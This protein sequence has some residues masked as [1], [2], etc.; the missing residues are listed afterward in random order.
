VHPECTPEKRAEVE[1]A[2]IDGERARGELERVA[3]EWDA[4]RALLRR[5][6]GREAQRL[7][8]VA[9]ASRRGAR[10]QCQRS[11]LLHTST[12]AFHGCA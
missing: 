10:V 6:R 12:G 4:E 3:G 9:H 1:V 11:A 7:D 2:C 5:P 8:A